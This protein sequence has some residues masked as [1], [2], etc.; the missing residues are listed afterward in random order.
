MTKIDRSR[1]K[2]TSLAV[3]QQ[4]DQEVSTIT[5]SKKSDNSS[6]DYLNVKDGSGIHKYRIYPPHP[7]DGGELYAVA[8]GVHFLPC[9]SPKR[10]KDGAVIKDKSGNDV[11]EIKIRPVFNAKIHGGYQ[12]DI[13][14]E[15]V[16]FA[17]QIAVE[18][19]PNDEK[20]RKE[21]LEPII[22]GYGSKH[23]GIMLRQSWVMYVDELLDNGKKIFGRLD[24]GKAIKER[25]NKIAASESASEPL[26]TDPFTDPEE[27]RAIKI[28]YDKNAQRAQDYYTTELYAPL[29]QGGKGQIQL[30][31]LSD[32]DLEK[33]E[34]YPSLKKMFIGTYDRKT[35]DQALKG[36]KNFD[37]ENEI[38]V[39][40]YEAFLDVADQLSSVLPETSGDDSTKSEK[41]GDE[42]D[43][44][45]RD[46]LKEF[47]R[48]N[49]LGL[50]INK[51]LSDDA[52]RAEI[53][54]AMSL[55]S[56]TVEIAPTSTVKIV[57]GGD[58]KST[59]VGE[60]DGDGLPWDKNG[61]DIKAA[62]IST[63]KA[64]AQDRLN[65]LRGKKA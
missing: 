33:F 22:G 39:F 10:D 26:G 34:T 32:D 11:T 35:F 36:L 45:D 18:T 38:G 20:K 4:A 58:T 3:T 5:G 63:A 6:A 64:T 43:N 28:T 54:E 7:A 9:D 14:E 15:Y 44:M 31:P 24:I 62:P 40:A 19:Y 57:S 60:D 13:I 41:S 53:R 52:L 48:D 21:F 27:G 8:K 49:K 30:F 51:T 1:F 17:Q 29:V 12:K 46:E 2:S 25:L 56:D 59:I 47:N 65:A 37:D 50:I 16:L 55:K 61:N 42:Y 23:S